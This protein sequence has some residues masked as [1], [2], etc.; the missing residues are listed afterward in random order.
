MSFLKKLEEIGKKA[1]EV[2]VELGTEG[3]K[4]YAE[5]QEKS[6][7][8]RKVAEAEAAQKWAETEALLAHC[9]PSPIKFKVTA[10]YHGGYPG[11][12]DIIDSGELYLGDTF[13]VWV[14][15]PT[16]V[17]IDYSTVHD[18]ELDNFKVSMMRS[19]LANGADNDVHRLKNTVAVHCR[20]NGVKQ[21]IKFEI[22]G[23]LSVHA[24][25]LNAQ[26]VVDHMAEFRH[27]FIQ[28]PALA[29]PA[30][31]TTAAPA[32]LSITQELE[33][34]AELHA[35]GVLDQDEFRAFKAKLLANL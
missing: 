16:V 28:E 4:R 31:P 34:P 30:A 23:G 11:M 10:N 18:L 8:Q 26:K 32:G 6:A 17:R 19:F 24:G 14:K 12:P 1:T 21:R 7:E 27:L 2:A 9:L 22:W 5:Y 35:K 20:V 25:A 33:R 29:A 3:Q 15:L 13:M